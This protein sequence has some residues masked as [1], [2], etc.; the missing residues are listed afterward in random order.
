MHKGKADPTILVPHF[1]FKDLTLLR[2][3]A[4][5]AKATPDINTATDMRHKKIA[6]NLI[7]VKKLIIF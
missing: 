3:F 2:Q 6:A 1:I 7:M 4:G 5:E